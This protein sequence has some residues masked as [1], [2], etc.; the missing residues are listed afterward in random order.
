M[1]LKTFAFLAAMTIASSASALDNYKIEDKFGDDAASKVT[2]AT[3][4]I[5]IS[6]GMVGADAFK[7]VA[8]NYGG[9]EK[10]EKITSMIG[11]RQLQSQRFD[12][13]YRG[14]DILKD[15]A[16]SVY[17]TSPIAGN[18]VFQVTRSIRFARDKAQPKIADLEAQLVGKYG[19]PAKSEDYQFDNG[20]TLVWY[21]GGKT[22][23]KDEE[24]CIRAMDLG[25][26]PQYFDRY[27]AALDKGNPD[28]V[29]VA[30]IRDGNDTDDRASE[31]KVAVT[32]ATMLGKSAKADYDLIM[33]EV[34]NLSKQA[35]A[36]PKL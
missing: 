33:S 32:D 30:E 21:L 5:G 18:K 13:E 10:V 34:E 6:P 26:N 3:D 4:I 19:K 29:I 28:V 35:V 11:P 20:K 7:I 36:A 27:I 8:E 16:I 2:S 17:L 12:A 1:K 22:V 23:C 25:Y 14:G 9:E 24:Y 31:L 15:G